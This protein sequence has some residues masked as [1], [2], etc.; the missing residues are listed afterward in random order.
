M[1]LQHGRMSKRTPYE[2]R[3]EILKLLREDTLTYTK[4]Q[5]KLSTNYDSVKNNCKELEVY[6]LVKITQHQ[7]HDENGKPFSEVGLTP[8]GRDIVKKLEKTQ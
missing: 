5:T 1:L 4:I 2:V 3:K 6:D 8:K 7:K